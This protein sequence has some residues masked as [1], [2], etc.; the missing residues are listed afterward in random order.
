MPSKRLIWL[1]FEVDLERGQLLV[2]QLKIYS[3]MEQ[4]KRARYC[5]EMP[6]TVLA[7]VIGRIMS[8]SLA[9][10]SLAR[11]MTRSMYAVLNARSSWCHQVL[12]TPEALE[13]LAFWLNNI[14]N[15][16]G[17]NIWPKASAI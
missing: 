14:D 15:F 2:L 4:M 17:Q 5:R 13:E 1:G 9:L 10:G 3:L 16:N 12:L 8:M 6:V 7:S 11:M